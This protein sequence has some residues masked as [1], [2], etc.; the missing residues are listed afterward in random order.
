MR[1]DAE[2]KT[3]LIEIENCIDISRKLDFTLE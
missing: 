1:L 3:V 2:E